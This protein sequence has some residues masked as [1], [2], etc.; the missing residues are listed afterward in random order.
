MPTPLPS[1]PCYHLLRHHRGSRTTFRL[2]RPFWTVIDMLA[3]K[4]GH[5]WQEWA[6]IELTN[7]PAGI[8][9]ASWLRV[10][11]LQTIQGE[12]HHG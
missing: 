10:R 12:H 6:A 3:N 9:A 5:S 8:G 4:T 7:K 2:E 1:S 11:C